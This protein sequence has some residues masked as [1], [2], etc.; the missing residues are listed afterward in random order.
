MGRKLFRTEAT[1][2][3]K[4]LRQERGSHISGVKT[5]QAWLAGHMTW[6][7]IHEWENMAEFPSNRLYLL[8]DVQGKFISWESLLVMTWKKIWRRNEIANNGRIS[9]VVK[10]SKIAGRCFVAIG[11]DNYKFIVIPSCPVV[12]LASS[13]L[14]CLVEARKVQ[15]LNMVKSV[16]QHTFLFL[17]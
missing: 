5:R 12:L 1:A 15:T 2:C 11:I 16:N 7:V 3:V 8:C 6:N 17:C 9:L 4:I 14:S 13:V 10:H